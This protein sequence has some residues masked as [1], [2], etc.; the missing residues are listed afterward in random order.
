L[1]EPVDDAA[2]VFPLFCQ[3]FGAMSVQEEL[4]AERLFAL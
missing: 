2:H 4:G 1:Q 3:E